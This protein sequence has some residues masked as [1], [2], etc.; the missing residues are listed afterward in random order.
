MLD[1]SRMDMIHYAPLSPEYSE[2]SPEEYSEASIRLHE[3]LHAPLNLESDFTPESDPFSP[4]PLDTEALTYGGLPFSRVSSLYLE[5]IMGGEYFRHL[6]EDVKIALERE[7]TYETERRIAKNKVNKNIL[8]QVLSERITSENELGRLNSV[9]DVDGMVNNA[10]VDEMLLET[11][12]AVRSGKATLED[13]VSLLKLVP[14]MG[15]IEVAKTTCPCDVDTA[16]DSQY[17]LFEALSDLQ[18]MRPDWHVKFVRPEDS[19]HRIVSDMDD[20]MNFDPRIIVSKY[21]YARVDTGAMTF[22][23]VTKQSNILLDEHTA[24]IAKRNPKRHNGK[25]YDV[26]PGS[27]MHYLRPSK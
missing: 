3:A 16:K 11:L 13:R 23:L 9:C 22:D 19:G 5:Q 10:G 24:G 20:K 4:T 27:I 17:V 18:G 14:E 1:M 25:I 2:P 7:M 21:V 6:P 15:S 12:V 26:Q 8:N